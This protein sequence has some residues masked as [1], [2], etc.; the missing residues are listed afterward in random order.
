MDNSEKRNQYS[1]LE[2][3][4]IGM[5]ARFPGANNIH[6]FWTNLENGIESVTFSTEEE[7]REIYNNNS[8]STNPD[9][10]PSQGGVIQDKY[11]FDASFFGY[12]PNEAQ[13]MEP[14]LRHLYECAW[15]ALEDAGCDPYTYD[16][17]I[18]VYV[19]GSSSFNWEA[20]TNLSGKIED[21]GQVVATYLMDKDFLGTR[22][23]FKLDLRGP[24]ITMRTACSTSLVTIHMACRYLLTGDCDIAL[25]GGVTIRDKESIGYI[26][27]E[28]M[29][30]SPDGHCRAFDNKAKGTVGGEGI[31]LV[32]L[33]RLKYAVSEGDNIYAVIKG[34]A[35]N[36]DGKQKI[37]FT[38][39]SIEGQ[40]Q[41]IKKALRTAKVNP[42]SITLI[43]AHGTA[44]PLGDPIEFEALK[45]AFDYGK[46][47]VCALGSVKTN[48]GHLDCAAGIAGFIK[49]VLAIH[50]RQIPPSLHFNSPNPAM[51]FEQ[52]PFYVNTLLKKWENKNYPLR[53]G[54]S[55]FGIGGTNAH[56][57]LEQAPTTDLNHQ[58]KEN[59][60]NKI[61]PPKF[62]LVILSAKS[63]PS[64]E[65]MTNNLKNH[66]NKNQTINLADIAHTLQLGR[67]AFKY[68][69]ISVV[70]NTDNLIAALS[71]PNSPGIKSGKVIDGSQP[72]RFFLFPGQGSQYINMGLDL[73]LNN[74]IF[75][76]EVNHC[77][78][79]LMDYMNYDL[80]ALVY[81]KDKN[82]NKN[83]LNHTHN[84]NYHE[85][86]ALDINQ[87]E[88][89]IEQ[90][91]IAQPL[92]FIIEYA[93]ARLLINWGIQPDAMLGHSIGEFTAACLSG[94]FSLEDA[95]SIIATR[96]KLVQKMPPGTMLGVE[97]S[98]MELNSLL[99]TSQ[100][101]EQVE[102]S[103]I[104]GTNHCTVSGTKKAINE[105]EKILLLKGI[106]FKQLR[107]SHAFHSKM[108]EP[109]MDTFAQKIE[110][111]TRNIPQIPF[112][113]NVTGKW[114][115]N[116]EAIS[117][118]YWA[119]HL[120]YPVRFYQGLNEL[121]KFDKAVLL[122]VGPGRVLT[123]FV[124]Q[125]PEKKDEQ[126]V[127]NLLRH[128][129][130]NIDD[131]Y[132]LLEKIG[133]MWI[134][135]M[136]VNWKNLH[137]SKNRKK[138]PLPTY[139]FERRPYPPQQI[140]HDVIKKLPV[141]NNA[142]HTKKTEMADWFYIPSWSREDIEN[143][144]LSQNQPIANENWLVLE[145]DF[146]FVSTLIGTNSLKEETITCAKV[147]DRFSEIEPGNFI[148]DPK[149]SL[150]YEKLIEELIK[151]NRVP[152]VIV[153]LLTLDE[154]DNQNK[155]LLYTH[156]S[157]DYQLD[158]GFN[159]LINLVQSI[160]KLGITKN[161]QILVIT[162]HLQD[163]TGE[164]LLS[165]IKAT[166]MGAVKVIPLEYRNINCRCIDIEILAVK[167]LLTKTQSDLLINEL[168]YHTSEPIVCIRGRHRWIQTFQPIRIE[169]SV[170]FPGRLREK[171]IYLITG[172]TGGMGF[173]FGKHLAQLLQARVILVSRSPFPPREQWESWLTTNKE[174]GKICKQIREMLE[175]EKKGARFLVLSADVSK[176]DHMMNVIKQ[177]QNQFGSI[178]GVLH[179]AGVPD[180]AGVIQR[181]TKEMSEKVLE[182]K[183]KGTLILEQVLSDTTLDFMV[184]F[185]SWGTVAYPEKFGQVAYCAAN[186]FLDIY[187]YYKKYR[188][189]TFTVTINWIDWS[190]IGMTVDAIKRKYAE[191]FE[192]FDYKNHMPDDS[193]TPEQGTEIF[194]RII[195]RNFPRVILSLNN[196]PELLI[197]YRT[198]RNSELNQLHMKEATTDEITQNLPLQEN[199]NNHVREPRNE[200]K[201]KL[202]EI[203][204][205]FFG[206]NEIRT[207]DD[208]FDLGGDSLQAI[209]IINVIQKKLNVKIPIPIFFNSPTIE[210]L[211][212]FIKNSIQNN[213]SALVSL[214]KKEYYSIS[215][216][217]KRIY[218]A[219]K[220]EETSTSYNQPMVRILE[221]KPD[222]Q[223]L[224]NSIRLLLK[225]HEI[226]RTSFIL[227]NDEIMQ[228]VNDLPVFSIDFVEMSPTNLQNDYN[229]QT[230]NVESY[231]REFI[232]PFDLSQSPLV[233]VRLIKEKED[234]YILVLDLHHIISDGISNLFLF[235]ELVS[236]YTHKNLKPI[237]FQYTDYAHW[238]NQWLKSE[239]CQNKER[240]WIQT[241][242]GEIPQLDIPL[243][244]PRPPEL[245]YEKGESIE[246][247]L[248]SDWFQKLNALAEE[249]DTTLFMLM[250]SIY[251]IL[252]FKYT[253]QEDIILGTPLSGRSHPDQEKMIG[254][255][256]NMAALRN[257]PSN[258][259]TFNDFLFQVKQNCMDAFENQDYPFD[260]LIT[261]L[262]LQGLANRNPLFTNEFAFQ[263]SSAKA[264]QMDNL[265][266]KPFPLE[267][268]FA[269]FDL[270]LQAVVENPIIYLKLRYSIQLFSHS[271]VEKML[272]RYIEIMEQILI[273]P[274]IPIGEIKTS[275]TV[276]QGIQT[277]DIDEESDFNF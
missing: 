272:K 32:V 50:H 19:G 165:P 154:H 196:L 251:I 72:Q 11:L 184:L 187:T 65:K 63:K 207:N 101:S 14:Q 87:L 237:R 82:N 144:V 126:S 4:V 180:L 86:I 266:M 79:I 262:G 105:F 223:L 59:D 5:A 231:V 17:L 143:S 183:V 153:H 198:N 269:K 119:S 194:H 270:H 43:E 264:I 209:T 128:P 188:N 20:R 110:N 259:K 242:E 158:L 167:L 195:D 47:D 185:S 16:G 112:I 157:L 28:G 227:V 156:E 163:V 95:I 57:I 56:I 277:A 221:G 9:F 159:S 36:N 249:T 276:M 148:F 83:N 268:K 239:D 7:I 18:G 98:E 111:V 226:L 129:N 131:Q 132:Y 257:Q 151:S 89:E 256:L 80:L 2:L 172:G 205:K 58:D 247:Q 44:T 48:I 241:F 103:A 90:T 182:A 64:L 68:R 122:E 224:E 229:Q 107:T 233:R 24:S 100:L 6:E 161:I 177:A 212:N 147:G 186:E 152:N 53:A 38:A 200:T 88:K 81:P 96:G 73:Y 13:V 15:H 261:K 35:V 222:F 117:P 92:I 77:F 179:T 51:D 26:Y 243:D 114:I 181:R 74:P 67:H 140:K 127:T 201:N 204:Q 235:E 121:L 8:I 248:D 206:F 213:Y 21:V 263:I 125:H 94:V 124:R 113:S 106:K 176:L 166:L 271:T 133:E 70:S 145:K 217:Q 62:H 191:K 250:L 3:A 258:D 178:N 108:L 139:P 1:G 215:S 120:R 193:V 190:E 138:V 199:A 169:K 60:E 41:V 12:T 273:N 189:D 137:L 220:M 33:K 175:L 118:T 136:S 238:Q 168:M 22:L 99:P 29:I 93:L 54:V 116:E 203:W 142:T 61:D 23:S 202:L 275:Y 253:G 174:E 267:R 85:S 27:Q 260:L 274:N 234:R 254:V 69:Q 228:R 66:I 91:E 240:H 219:Q 160:G 134:T 102:I 37:G 130:Q 76:K 252:L 155:K 232:Q 170:Q 39:P 246:L 40:A 123:S 109:V 225:R 214:E 211:S 10:V 265:K 210:T 115:T 84:D 135:G 52:S 171:G 197:N 34:S 46:G 25:A 31:G 45:R 104:N 216:A 97:I 245:S 218:I 75:C 141:D 236:I 230:S 146:D 173:T 49:T 255:F 55:S 162:N 164:E 149:N 208:F 30:E 71:S 192:N 78:E 244:F 42:E 150:H